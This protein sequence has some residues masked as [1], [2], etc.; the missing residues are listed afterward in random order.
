MDEDRIKDKIDEIEKFI[1]ELEE[2]VPLSL[3][4]YI[5]NYRVKAI[6]ERYFEKIIEAVVDLAFLVI[7]KKELGTPEEDKQAFDIL[8]KSDVISN[9]LN[10]SLQDAKSMRNFIAH[11]YGKIDDEKVFQSVSEE[12]IPDVK[13]FLNCIN[14]A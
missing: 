7:K 8:F 12:L 4:I 2:N 11:Q 10:L 1:I 14:K 3:E 6:C 5:T 13:E 9:K